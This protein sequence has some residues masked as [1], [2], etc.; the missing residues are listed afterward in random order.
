MR[1]ISQLAAIE[2][3]TMRKKLDHD[4]ISHRMA[5]LPGWKVENDRLLRAFTFPD[6]KG[7]LEAIWQALDAANK[8]IVI[9]APFSLVRDPSRLDDVA[10]ILADLLEAIRVIADALEPFVQTGARR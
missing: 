10:Q 8:Y 1:S 7:A 3:A 2:L 9:T 6:F 4:E 5:S